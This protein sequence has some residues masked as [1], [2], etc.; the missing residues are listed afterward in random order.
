GRLR[1]AIHTALERVCAKRADLVL[2]ASADL[3]DRAH[4]AGAAT[5]ELVAVSASPET[6]RTVGQAPVDLR[7]QAEGRLVVVCVARLHPQKRVDVVI[8][9]LAGQDDLH[10]FVAGD[11]P[12]RDRLT[13]QIAS[14]RAP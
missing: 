7:R 1:R 10:A 2:V 4:R 8:D 5:A 11:G 6:V 14:T 12:L 3:L 13:Q 9:A